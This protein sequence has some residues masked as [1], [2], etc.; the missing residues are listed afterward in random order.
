MIESIE[1]TLKYIRN[2]VVEWKE[3]KGYEDLYLI[4]SHGDV[5]SL[6]RAVPTK[7]KKGLWTTRNIKGRILLANDINGYQYVNLCRNA[8]DQKSA[9]VH[10]LVAQAFIPNPQNKQEVN[11]LDYK[12]WHNHKEN[13]EWATH[14]ENMRHAHLNGRIKT[15]QQLGSKSNFAKLNESQVIE[16]KQRIKTGES[17]DS[18]S[19]DYAVGR[20][21]ISEIKSGR[22]WAHIP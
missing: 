7:S 11:H 19:K 10:R 21:C 18:I 9:K 14:L 20:T 2:D 4:S 8:S 22:S 16:I 1:T 15:V 3:I 12:P 6:D 13:L 17:S 5:K